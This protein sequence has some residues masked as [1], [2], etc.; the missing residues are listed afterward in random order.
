M[1][2]ALKIRRTCCK[3]ITERINSV[4]AII[5]ALQKSESDQSCR[6]MLMKASERLGKVLNET[7]IRLFVDSKVQK[8][9]VDSMV[10][11]HKIDRDEKEGIQ[12]I[13]MLGKCIDKSKGEAEKEIKRSD[14]E[15]QRE[16]LL[17]EKEVKKLQDVTE[18]E[19]KRR[20][21]EEFVLRKQLKRK[22][23]EA[24]KD[25]RCRQKEEDVLKNRHALQKQASL[26]ERFLKKGKDSSP[27]QK[28]PSPAKTDSFSNWNLEMIE[29]VTLSMD[30]ALLHF[31]EISKES[32]WKSH[33][34]YWRHL[35][36]GIRS[37]GKQHWGIRQT[38]KVELVKELKLT[39]SSQPQCDNE[40]NIEKLPNVYGDTNI[41][42]RLD[43][44][45]AEC[46]CYSGPKHKWKKQL[47]QFDKSHRPA[48]YGI[49]PKKSKIIGPRPFSEDPNLDYEIDS[50]EEW[51]EEEPGENLSDCD[52]DG[53]E[54]S[55]E[56]GPSK[57]V[58]ED[59]S[60]DGFFV[61]DGYLCK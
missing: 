59:D 60:E 19:E 22:Q 37:N 50:D 39:M 15:L 55:L 58:D 17:S 24:E 32:V 1:R 16:K 29:S 33:T 41:V 21:K 48:F 34:T 31:D 47:F 27:L 40:L 54:D 52:K 28:D 23:E 13:N 8:N 12:E 26:M 9:K 30:S 46:S 4:S 20:K 14:M 45:N 42:C 5:A 3:K 6:Q 57:V 61:P 36:H 18:N 11:K 38:P 43:H 44:T 56:E 53:E 2:G 35:G 7:D 10:Q 25:L 51:E 49:W